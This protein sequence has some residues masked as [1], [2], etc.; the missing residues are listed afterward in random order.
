MAGPVF[1]RAGSVNILTSGTIGSSAAHFDWYCSLVETKIDDGSISRAT[2]PY[3]FCRSDAPS[4][5]RRNCF[6]FSSDESGRRREP[7]P[8]ARISA[9]RVMRVWE[10][11]SWAWERKKRKFQRLLLLPPPTLH[12]PH[13]SFRLRS[14]SIRSSADLRRAL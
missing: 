1:R 12:S 14:G 4:K 7:T 13:P 5:M 3:V 11:G 10:V 6:G 2:R 8:P 9:V